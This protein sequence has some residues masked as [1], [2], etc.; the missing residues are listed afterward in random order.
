MKQFSWTNRLKVLGKYRQA[1]ALVFL[2]AVIVLREPQFL[3]TP[4]LWA[5]EGSYFLKYAMLHGVLNGLFF[6]PKD[7]AGYFLLCAT[8][9]STIA[10]Y[11]SL[12]WAPLITTYFSFLYLVVLLAVVLYGK[13]MLWDTFAKKFSI[14]MAVLVIASAD[15]SVWLN[16]INLQIYC[17]IFTLILLAENVSECSR[18]R[19]Y[20]QRSMLFFSGLSGL[21][22]VAMLPA[23]V[24]KC[25]K[26]KERESIVHASIL[27]ICGIVQGA[28]VL[29]LILLGDIHENKLVYVS[30]FKRMQYV[31]FFHIIQPILGRGDVGYKFAYGLVGLTRDDLSRSAAGIT[32]PDMVLK[33]LVCLFLVC[34]VLFMLV[35]KPRNEMQ[36]PVLTAFLCIVLF[37]SI[38]A[39]SG[40][41]A[42][43]YAAVP[44]FIFFS[45]VL[46][47]FQRFALRDLGTFAGRK[48]LCLLL[49]VGSAICA[50][51]WNYRSIPFNYTYGPSS[52]SWS[53]EILQWQQNPHYILS[54]FPHPPWKI[55]LPSRENLLEINAALKKTRNRTL[56]AGESLIIQ[57][58]TFRTLPMQMNLFVDFTSETGTIEGMDVTAKLRCNDEFIPLEFVRAHL[59]NTK[60][61]I[62][63]EFIHRFDP[64]K[65]APTLLEKWNAIDALVLEQTGSA[66]VSL[67]VKEI[68]VSSMEEIPLFKLR[69]H[70]P[71][72]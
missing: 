65:D 24:I 30:V 50:G 64:M 67:K 29:V 68:K 61:R 59:L 19:K 66:I 53:S 21:Y 8:F 4:R 11:L 70:F 28:V 22:S 60:K 39:S 42:D 49:L 69:T 58:K 27:L 10:A 47:S 46:G 20:F 40:V 48:S 15:S 34:V 2:V 37:V 33:G 44:A 41:P 18:T 13:S 17:A 35:K 3:I 43:R 6:I 52:P 63:L 25:V 31:F 9:P 12:V 5:E 32:S 14:C 62:R 57:D 36:I 7:T 51:L 23:F 55:Y 54:I 16:T 26:T 56:S 38:G 45:L 71:G 1:A 72:T